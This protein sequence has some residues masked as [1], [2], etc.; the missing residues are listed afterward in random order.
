V[1]ETTPAPHSRVNAPTAALVRLADVCGVSATYTAYD[2][3]RR[4]SSARAIRA[5]LATMGVEAGDDAACQRAADRLEAERRS[6]PLPPVTVRR[7][8][9]ARDVELH[10]PEGA[11]AGLTLTLESGLAMA[12]PEV[13]PGVFRLPA[14]LPLGYHTLSASVGPVEAAVEQGPTEAPGTPGPG[15]AS[16]TSRLIVAPVRLRAPDA[17]IAK[18]PWGFMAQLYSVRSRASWGIGDLADLRDLCQ[19]AAVRTGADFVLVNPLH[20]AEPV[21]PL[22]P[23]PYLPSSRLF[24]NPI[25]IRVE[26]IPEV[27]YM[28]GADRSLIDWAAEAPRA[29]SLSPALINRDPIW[30]AKRDALEQVFR[31]PRPAA[32]AGAFADFRAR[33]GEALEDFATWCAVIEAGAVEERALEAGAADARAV[34]GESGALPAALASPRAPGIAAFRAAHRERIEFYA[35]LQWVADE[36]RGAAQDAALRAGMAIGVMTDLAVGVHP[37][38]ADAW[39]FAPVLARG[40]GVGAPPDMYNQQGQNWSQPPFLPRAL[41]EAGYEPFRAV[42]RAALRHAGALRIDHILGLF[43]LWWVPDTGEGE[44]DGQGDA[45]D[46]AYVR[47]DHEALFAVL[48]LEAERAGTMVIG[49]DLGTVE[50]WVADYLASRGILGTTVVWWEREADGSLRPPEHQRADVL[51][52]ATTHD[53]PPTAAYL[54]GAGVDLREKLGLLARPVEEVRAEAAAERAEMVDY[55][56]AR[57]WATRGTGGTDPSDADLL[58]GIHRAVLAAPALLAGV[59]LTDAVGDLRTQN[60]PGTDREYP[61]WCVPLTDGRGLPVVLDS[62]FDHPRLKALVHAIRETRP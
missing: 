3:E 23:S 1:S 20:A 11:S 26:D 41:E 8:G 9:E 33:A 61:N 28:P 42:V 5:I 12:L 47:Y 60:Q 13:H 45:A 52:T 25:Y 21:P 29:A 40:I 32:R 48:C 44:R 53:I 39:A 46:G 19:L 34:A 2:G 10:V 62:L 43:R 27:A 37:G 59:A 57:G 17:V 50:P 22:T 36:Q 54:A 16:E 49:E 55:L 56:V 51:A 15:A 58:I 18:R 6:R 7:A 4:T 38:G 24:V 31:L 35:W 30:R 14:D